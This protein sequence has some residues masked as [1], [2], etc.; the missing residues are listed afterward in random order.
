[1]SVV[2]MLQAW[3]EMAGQFF[4]DLRAFVDRNRGDTKK[5][6][7]EPDRSRDAE[8]GCVPLSDVLIA[9][10]LL[11]ARVLFKVWPERTAYTLNQIERAIGVQAARKLAKFTL[12]KR[13][14]IAGDVIEIAGG[15]VDSAL[16]DESAAKMQEA[17]AKIGAEI[18]AD[19]GTR[20]LKSK[21]KRKRNVRDVRTRHFKQPKK[22]S[23]KRCKSR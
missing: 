19:L 20:V 11:K 18:R 13:V 17:V 22:R 14:P 8:T 10:E 3:D 1:M 5:V 12:A 16:E 21:A 23:F 7:V 6:V 4:G 15:L 2:E 9:I